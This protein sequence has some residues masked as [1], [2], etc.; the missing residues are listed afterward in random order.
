M[1]GFLLH[2]EITEVVFYYFLI[3][4]SS[5]KPE[6][7]W[8][9]FIIFTLQTFQLF[10][11]NISVIIQACNHRQEAEERFPTILLPS[12][13]LFW[14][15]SKHRGNILADVLLLPSN[16]FKQLRSFSAWSCSVCKFL[17]CHVAEDCW[18]NAGLSRNPGKGEQVLTRILLL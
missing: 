9:L 14:G 16:C 7:I 15:R 12:S 13:H 6:M 10:Y 17:W 2:H 3:L 4:V 5:C 11:L 8:Y 18:G 1:T